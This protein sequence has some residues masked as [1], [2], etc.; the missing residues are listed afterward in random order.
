M[1]RSSH[2][3]D[4]KG[5]M[6]QYA[7]SFPLQY[8][9]PPE[10]HDNDATKDIDLCD[11]LTDAIDNHHGAGDWP[12]N[13]FAQFHPSETNALLVGCRNIRKRIESDTLPEYDSL[14]ITLTDF[15]NTIARIAGHEAERT[16]YLQGTLERISSM[17]AA[18]QTFL[19]STK[20][21]DLESWFMDRRMGGL[22]KVRK[23][24][25]YIREGCQIVRDLMVY[26]RALHPV[27]L[28]PQAPAL[29][30]ETREED[31]RVNQE[32]KSA[33]SHVAD[34]QRMMD[35]TKNSQG[36]P[37]T[38]SQRIYLPDTQSQGTQL[39]DTQ[40]QEIQLPDTQSQG[41]QLPDTQSQRTEIPDTQWQGTH[42]HD[43]ESQGTLLPDTQSQGTQ[44]PDAQSQGTGLEHEFFSVKSHISDSEESDDAELD[45]QVLPDT[46]EEERP[47]EQE[48]QWDEHD[49]MESQETLRYL[50]DQ[51]ETFGSNFSARLNQ[52]F[53]QG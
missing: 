38:Q 34:A 7:W 26:A 6:P 9:H 39:P 36:L 25:D 10:E 53:P 31:L 35:G 29:K 24:G 16:W 42:L 47:I 27:H 19:A 14:R 44:L 15:S 22:A 50:G 8:M 37:D 52:T 51:N 2:T 40:S 43:T 1:A 18:A 17:C 23:M 12:H 49:S 33:V 41:T 45:S 30:Q 4:L 48:N 20:A 5:D 32:N 3:R 28:L 46:Q 21:S 11:K 13:F